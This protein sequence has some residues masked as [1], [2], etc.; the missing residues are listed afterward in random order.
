MKENQDVYKAEEFHL[1]Q[2]Y[3]GGE[4]AAE[5]LVDIFWLQTSQVDIGIEVEVEVE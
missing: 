2:L 5:V 3:A 4:V 1:V